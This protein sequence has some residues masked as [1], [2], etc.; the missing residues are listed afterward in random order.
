MNDSPIISICIPTY[1]RKD[2][3][4]ELVSNILKYKGNEIEVAVLDNLSKNNSNA[5]LTTSNFGFL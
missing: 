4:Y 2:K 3:V 1:N 5:C